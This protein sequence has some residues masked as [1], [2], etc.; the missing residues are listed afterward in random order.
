M[1]QLLDHAP[2]FSLLFFFA[3]FVYVAVRAYRPS[4]KTALQ[5]HAYIP[6]REDTSEQ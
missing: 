3:V 5:E 1:S 2:T 4:A 6:L